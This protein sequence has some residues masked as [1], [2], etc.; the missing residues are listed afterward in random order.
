LFFVTA[1][2]VSTFVCMAIKLG[3][4][5]CVVLALLTI[6]LFGRKL[7]EVARWLGYRIA[8]GR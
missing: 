2:A 3:W 8:G 5:E 7:P 4:L 1:V 6:V